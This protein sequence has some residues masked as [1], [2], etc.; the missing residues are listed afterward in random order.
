MKL[1]IGTLAVSLVIA[2]AYAGAFTGPA[3]RKVRNLFLALVLTLAIATAALWLR[4]G[5]DDDDEARPANCGAV[6]C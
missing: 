4:S 5:A 3:D 2:L 6:R 1:A